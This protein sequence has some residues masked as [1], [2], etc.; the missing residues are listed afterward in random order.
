[1]ATTSRIGRTAAS[2]SARRPGRPKSKPG[3]QPPLSEH[4][5]HRLL[6]GVTDQRAKAD[7]ARRVVRDQPTTRQLAEDV[8]RWRAG[9]DLPPV[10][11]PPMDPVVAAVRRATSALREAWK[12]AELEPRPGLSRADLPDLLELA[13]RR[14][15]E[16]RKRLKLPG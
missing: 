15:A 8:A 3:P 16:L 11:R 14:I 5:Q 1:M 10:G 9:Q 7:F 2:E 6:L 4:P 12:E 13:E